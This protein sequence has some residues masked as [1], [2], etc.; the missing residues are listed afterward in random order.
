[1]H[2][3]EASINDAVSRPPQLPRKV[4]RQ[5]N[6]Q[7]KHQYYR[8]G[9]HPD[10][11]DLVKADRPLDAERVLRAEDKRERK[12]IKRLDDGY[13]MAVGEKCARERLNGNLLLI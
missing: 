5:L 13:Q 8:S 10:A 4:L 11:T 9:Q 7:A 3:I 12:N 1:M 6:R 2:P